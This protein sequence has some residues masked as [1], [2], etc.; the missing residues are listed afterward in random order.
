MKIDLNQGTYFE[1]G[2]ELGKY[3]SLPI[4][5]LIK[6]AEDLQKL[7]LTIASFEIDDLEL[8]SS[9]NFEIELIDFKKSSAVPCFSFS[10]RSEKKIGE[11]W[12]VQRQIVNDKF[13]NILEISAQGNYGKL[14]EMYPEPAKRNRMV[15]NLYNFVGDFGNAPISVVNYDREADYFTPI[16]K[17]K[18]FK[19]ALK[20]MLIA[21]EIE[22]IQ[23]P[24]ESD[25][26]VGKIRK[27]INSKGKI[28]QKVL[29]TYSKEKFSLEYAPQEI[30]SRG[31]K[32]I[33]KYP[34]RCLF[35]KEDNYYVIHSEFLGIIGTGLTENDAEES[36]SEE[37][38]YLYNKLNSLDENKL[39]RHNQ[40]IKNNLNHFV[41]KIEK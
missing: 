8:A 10:P 4:N 25:I 9:E 21:E 15:E 34:L 32:Y 2:G 40:L 41:E 35:E 6:F 3:N 20:K 14:V 5:V 29:D 16:Y 26:F 17:L 23:L 38:D 11:N 13:D 1:V 36:F 12:S 30:T 7:I 28:R 19:P 24:F 18:K 22:D 27:T 31:T 37:F 39:T 33:L